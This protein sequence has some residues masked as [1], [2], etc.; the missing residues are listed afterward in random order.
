MQKIKLPEEYPYLYETHLHT[1]QSSA[2]AHNTGTE[3]AKACKEAGY[4]GIIVTDH[5]WDGNTAVYRMKP[6]KEWVNEFAKGYEDA[7]HTGDKIGLDVFFGYEAGFRG[8]EFL[9]YG[10]DK[11]FMLTHPELRQASVEEQYRLVKQAGGMV[12]HAHPFREEFYIP[13][14]RLCPDYVDGVEGINATHSNKQSISH[15]NPA[16]DQRA[17]AYAKENNLP[18]TAGSDIHMTSL[19]GG[20]VAFKRKLADIHD[21]IKAVSEGEDYLLTN[22]DEWFK[23]NGELYL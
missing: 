6:W 17:I 22:G 7:K 13:K 2:C 9:I 1:S 10:V 12:I 18:M 19:L 14:I 15:Y 23:K 4:T 5:N 11:D 20:G 3:M 21:F 16:F 8:T